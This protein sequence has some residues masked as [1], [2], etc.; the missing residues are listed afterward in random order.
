MRKYDSI[1]TVASFK[2]FHI[3]FQNYVKEENIEV[4]K[5]L[6]QLK[7]VWVVTPSRIYNNETMKLNRQILKTTCH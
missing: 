6:G 4:M 5:I 1:E 3:D 2:Q 7:E